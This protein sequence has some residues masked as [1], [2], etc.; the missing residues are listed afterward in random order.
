[1][2]SDA[3]YFFA[4]STHTGRLP[5]AII[6]AAPRIFVPATAMSPTGPM[7]MTST[8]S[9][10][11]TSASSTPWN[12]VGTISESMHASTTLISFGK[13]ARFPSASFT[14]KY[15]AN[16]PSLKLENFQPASM[17]PECIAYPAWASSEFQSGVI[18]GTRTRSPGL[19]SF[20]SAPTSTTSAQ[21]SCPRIMSCRSP[22]APS[23]TV[24]TSE[25]QM[26]IASG[27][28]IASM[29]PQAGLSF[30]TQPTEPILSIA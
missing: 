25:V 27:L 23:H 11:C 15:S 13:C 18:A 12:P 17:P 9:P 14:W 4:A 7:P 28:Q 20:T 5:T 10:N 1:M 2:I 22:T 16:T 24:C 19:K 21:H 3:P 29:A 6:R 26:A 8:T 30:S